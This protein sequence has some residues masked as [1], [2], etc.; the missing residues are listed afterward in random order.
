MGGKEVRGP[1]RLEERCLESS[2]RKEAAIPMEG[3]ELALL[4]LPPSHPVLSKFPPDPEGNAIDS[5]RVAWLVRKFF[6]SSTF[7]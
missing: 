6:L 1:C 7:L 3:T 2:Q 4:T 5:P